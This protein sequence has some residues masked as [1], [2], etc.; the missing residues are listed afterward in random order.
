MLTMIAGLALA[1]LVER[2]AVW[3]TAAVAVVAV[4]SLAQGA[5]VNQMMDRDSRFTAEAWLLENVRPGQV[6]GMA[7]PRAYLPRTYPLPTADVHLDW[8]EIA[9]APPE[10]LVVN[11]EHARRPR[12]RAFFAPL[13][14]GTS[15]HYAPVATFKSS[16]GLALLAYFE[17]FRNRQEDP[18][19]TSTKS[20][21]RSGCSSGAISGTDAAD[22]A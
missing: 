2:R 3:A 4:Y 1:W 10:Y 11:L 12:D 20:T 7:G 8:T 15:S 14:D 9:T 16:P 6:V 22:A 18:Q 17:V 19:P 13:L 21:P 5:S